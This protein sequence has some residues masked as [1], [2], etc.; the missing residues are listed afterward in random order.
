MKAFVTA[1]VYLGF[2]C[3]TTTTVQLLGFGLHFLIVLIW[4]VIAVP[5]A[6]GIFA[7]VIGWYFAQQVAF[8]SK[9]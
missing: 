3:I 2:G 4:P 1:C 6:A 9:G 8:G 5:V 7:C